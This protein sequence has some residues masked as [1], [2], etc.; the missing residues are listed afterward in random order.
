MDKDFFTL[1]TFSVNLQKSLSTY[2]HA[3]GLWGAQ[4]YGLAIAVLND[5]KQGLETRAHGGASGMPELT[6]TSPLRPLQKD[7]TDLKAHMTLLLKHWEQDNSSVYFERVPSKVP[8]E[9]KLLSGLKLTK[10]TPYTI[11]DVDPLPLS[12]PDGG[13]QRSDSDLARQLQEQLNSGFDG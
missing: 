2:F 9:K 13:I 3:R 11:E 1:V 10:P 8:E 4:D 12:L 5:A 7:L 6:K